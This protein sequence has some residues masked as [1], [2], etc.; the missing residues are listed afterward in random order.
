LIV[1]LVPYTFHLSPAERDGVDAANVI[2]W[3]AFAVDYL[4]RLYLALDRRQYVRN[5]LVDLLIVI[6]PF[7]RPIRA[8]RLLRLIRV[9][10]V[11]GV[12]QRR[13]ASVQARTVSYVA[14]T[15]LVATLVAS[16]AIYDVERQA[17]SGNIK[18]MGD[19]LW[20][21]VTTIF[22]VG[23]GDR[24]PTTAA[25]RVIA[26]CLMGVGIALLGVITAAIAAWFVSHLRQVEQAEVHSKA[27]LETV[28]AE[29]QGLHARL[30]ALQAHSAPS[31]AT[32]RSR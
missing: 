29:V 24:Y 6:V 32:S 12:A 11:A 22:T 17:K 1:L 15:A 19:A 14:T 30:D 27:T 31:E 13:A 10:G 7:L 21:S 4:V 9:V 25:G 28:L 26:V 5:N 3:L 2:I 20:W 8:V 23:Y 18:S 16:F